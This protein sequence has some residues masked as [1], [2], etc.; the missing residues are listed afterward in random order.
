MSFFM[1]SLQVSNY[2][3]PYKLCVTDNYVKKIENLLT[4]LFSIPLDKLPFVKLRHFLVVN[5]AFF[6]DAPNSNRVV[7]EVE[8][9]D[10]DYLRP[11]MPMLC[12]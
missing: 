4:G 12:K 6:F 2:L 5:N 10:T 9:I 3:F 1:I 8:Y 11:F 7:F